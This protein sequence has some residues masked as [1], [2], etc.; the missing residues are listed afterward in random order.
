M[1]IRVIF[2][3]VSHIWFCWLHICR[4]KPWFPKLPVGQRVGH[5]SFQQCFGIWPKKLWTVENGFQ[6]NWGIQDCVLNS[7]CLNN[8]CWFQIF[9]IPQYPVITKFEFKS[10]WCPG[11]PHIFN[12][13]FTFIRISCPLPG[14][15][16]WGSKQTSEVRAG[17]ASWGWWWRERIQI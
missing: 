11:V 13:K 9:K 2:E 5:W 8:R 1:F 6:R 17:T 7:I 10:S 3:Q 15:A 12:I 16:D 14:H 4:R